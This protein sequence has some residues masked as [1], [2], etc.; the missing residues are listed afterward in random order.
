[1]KNLFVVLSFQLLRQ[2]QDGLKHLIQ[3]VKDDSHDLQLMENSLQESSHR[4]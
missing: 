2:Q 3:I 4:R 1:M